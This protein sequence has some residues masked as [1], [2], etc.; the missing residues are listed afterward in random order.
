MTGDDETVVESD[1]DWV[2]EVVPECEL[3]LLLLD[4]FTV[5]EACC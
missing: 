1:F 3:V 4:V 2:T 5:F